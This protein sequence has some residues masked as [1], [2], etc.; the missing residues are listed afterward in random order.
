ME[1][2]SSLV[3][4][5]VGNYRVSARIGAGGMG[6]VYRATDERLNRE[7]AI[8][9]LLPGY[10]ADQTSLRRFEHEALALAALNHPNLLAIYDIGTHAGMPYIVSE[11]LEGETLRARLLQGALP[12]HR[13][14]DFAAQIVRALVAA[15]EK[16]IVHRDLKPDNIFITT[17]GHIKIL[18]FGLAKL[19]L[20]ER[21]AASN[22]DD[23]KTLTELT[24]TQQVVGTAAYMSPEQLR[25]KAIDYRSDI[26]AFGAVFYEMLTSRRAFK[27]HSTADII[28]S[29]LREE[30]DNPCE[31][32]P[33]INPA[34]FLIIR[35]CL[36]KRPEDRF[37]SGRDLL[38][39]LETLTDTSKPSGSSLAV[40]ESAKAR[41]S[42][43]KLLGMAVA[44]L[45]L[46]GAT[47]VYFATKSFV[48]PPPSFTQVTFMRGSI[49]SARFTADGNTVLYGA[50]WDGNP[51]DIFSTHPGNTESR[52]LGLTNADL[53]S[54]SS[55]GELAILLNRHGLMPWFNQGTLARVA[56]GGGTPKEIVENV[57]SAD[58]S[59]DGTSLAIIRHATD[60]Q[61]LEFPIGTTLFHTTG[62][63]TDVRVSPNGDRVA[64][65]EHP[66]RW[67]D[68]G[69]V[70]VV[71]L[72]GRA[73]RLSEEFSSERG[74]AW[75][76]RGDEIWFTAT[77]AGESLA[78]YAITLGG[79]QRVAYRAPTSLQLHDIGHDGVVLL[80]SYKELTP[81][82]AL[83]P[84]QTVE[85]DLSWLSQITLFD[86]S[87][88]GRTF[89]FQYY[90]EGSGPNYSSY[91]GKTDGSPPV[92]LGEGAAISLSPDGKW[93]IAR[94][95]SSRQTTLLPTGAGQV[96]ILVRQGIVDGGDDTW[97]QDGKHIVFT[98]QEPGKAERCYIQDIEGG[99]PEPFGPEGVTTP[100][101]S[102]NGKY[103][104]ARQGGAYVLVPLGGGKPQPVPGLA[105][106]EEAI[107]W[108]E[109]SRWLFVYRPEPLMKLFEVDPVTGNRQLVRPI[110]HS[111]PAGAIGLPQ[112]FVSANGKSSVYS[113]QQRL[114]DLY[115]AKKMI[116]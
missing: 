81:V 100:R 96:R 11:L 30:P 111:D 14:V 61:Y 109:D 106:E 20:S 74:L 112:L 51:V 8:K 23:T 64:F 4:Q 110:N 40:A 113:F 69:W 5:I 29:I 27:G 63:L 7:V 18:D 31:T 77:H 26:F 48:P 36:E 15:H 12:F 35:H 3:G 101:V 116:R 60:E 50:S 95:Y 114:S 88:D 49:W 21:P 53:L 115:V 46:V 37:Q 52:S 58:W 45:L 17:G 71:D 62:W 2:H 94:V 99:K 108:S 72:K 103:M 55:K 57:Q 28:S 76:P 42:K 44:S 32:N 25:G 107:R 10:G 56:L 6:E 82:I 24:G 86:L 83:P 1:D 89:L 80:S 75:S 90:G 34:T 47:I 16:G 68:R 9:T 59:P 38:F 54:V 70:S 78:L 13:A 67:D 73:R 87:E 105:P 104:L 41:S 79:K 33:N 97:L 92:R 39:D 65:M 102:P 93:A 43:R 84:G 22:G 98:G 19:I 85:R 66:A 91:L